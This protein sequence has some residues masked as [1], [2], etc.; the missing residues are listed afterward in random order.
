LLA[1]TP[2]LFEQA[3]AGVLDG[4]AKEARYPWSEIVQLEI[5]D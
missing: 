1:L 2:D 5:V 3:K 4:M